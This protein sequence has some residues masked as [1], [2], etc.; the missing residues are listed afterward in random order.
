MSLVCNS[1]LADV[2]LLI[3]ERGTCNR[4]LFT[5]VTTHTDLL[6]STFLPVVMALSLETGM[7]AVASLSINLTSTCV[8]TKKIRF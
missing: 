8:S 1:T 2:N 5:T 6:P 4:V 3:T 7:I